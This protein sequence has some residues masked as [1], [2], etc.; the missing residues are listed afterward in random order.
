MNGAG[1]LWISTEASSPDQA[2]VV[3]AN[4]GPEIPPEVIDSMFE[5]FFTTKPAGEGTGLGLDIVRRIVNS[6]G[7]EI[8]VDSSAT[9]TEFRI[10]LPITASDQAHH[11][12]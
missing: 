3:V 5:P 8:G 4:D 11:E 12:S 9:R 1:N 10:R 2:V 7:G 6:H